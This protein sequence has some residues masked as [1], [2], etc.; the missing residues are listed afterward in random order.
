MIVDSYR[1][2][3]QPYVIVL[4]KDGEP[5]SMLI[6]RLER[7]R[8]TFRLGYIAVARPQVRCL[9]FVYGAVRGNDS[10]ENIDS[11]V[12]EV[13]AGLKRGAADVALLEFPSVDSTLYNFALQIP[14]WLSRDFMPALQGHHALDLPPRIDD[15]YSRLSNGRRK[16]IRRMTKKLQNHPVGEMHI[17]CYQTE[18][19]LDRLFR[20]AEQIARKTYQRGLGVGFSDS[21]IV[22]ER[23]KLAAQQGW[24]RT[25]ILYLGNRP[26]AFWIGMLYG[27]SFLSEYMGFDPE[28]RHL[29][30]GMVLM[31]QVIESFCNGTNGDCLSDL[32]FG[33]GDAEYKTLLGSRSWREGSLFIFSPTIKGL[34]L[35]LIHTAARLADMCARQVLLSLRVSSRFKR[36]WRDQL[37][38]R[39]AVQTNNA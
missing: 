11:L 35:K 19:D 36:A 13:I 32:D 38:R 5:E 24:L 27:S 17:S 28:F 14:N 23:L 9:T 29:S 20:D 3:L 1:E 12:R 31:M 34:S 2:V 7:K 26:C 18:A 8:L 25:Y 21:P 37:S 30:P 16:E 39:G 33:L 22:R 10:Q 4:Y 6:G 15:V